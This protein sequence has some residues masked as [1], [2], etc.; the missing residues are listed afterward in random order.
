MREL[1]I[2]FI[3]KFMRGAHVG[4]QP[5]VQIVNARISGTYPSGGDVRVR[6]QDGYHSYATV[7]IQG[8]AIKKFIEAGLCENMPV[9]KILKFG[10]NHVQS[11]KGKKLITITD[12]ELIRIEKEIISY[13]AAPCLPHSGNCEDYLAFEKQLAKTDAENQPIVT[14]NTN[15]PGVTKKTAV[16]TEITS[17]KPHGIICPINAINP[18]KGKFL[19][20][21]VCTGKDSLKTINAA[22]GPTV[23]LNFTLADKDGNDVRIVAFGDRA[24]ELDGIIQEELTISVDT[25][26]KALKTANKQYNVTKN[27]YEIVLKPD[28]Q[29][30]VV[31]DPHLK[32]PVPKL[33]LQRVLLS[34]IQYKSGGFVDILGIITKIGNT[35]EINTKNGKTKKRE[36]QLVDE[37]KVVVKMTLWG[38]K[39]NEYDTELSEGDSIIFKNVTVREFKSSYSLSYGVGTKRINT[40]DNR[41]AQLLLNW[42][43]SHGHEPDIIQAPTFGGNNFNL[44]KCVLIENVS[45][46]SVG[47]LEGVYFNVVCRVSI[48]GSTPCYKAC[49]NEGCMKKVEE[50]N[51]Q[52]R[53]PKCNSTKTTFKWL[54]ILKC[55]VYDCSGKQWVTFFGDKAEKLTGLSADAM[56]NM[57]RMEDNS[58]SR[59]LEPVKNSTFNLRIRAKQEMY[60]GT[61]STKWNC[62]AVEEVKM[63][64]YIS[65]LENMCEKMEGI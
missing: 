33:N 22:K 19:I 28:C 52:F 12:F 56:G 6:L 50:D 2:G 58:L 46:N 57:Q 51:D 45:E 43:E 23:V 35:D 24:T 61:Y 49:S 30:A 11:S 64:E 20:M 26:H 39:C 32:V 31:E 37:S 41:D 63:A 7:V 4:M 40:T 65:K 3:Q 16:K 5:I 21:G 34:D 10:V 8:H 47:T 27:E 53:C 29:V 54:A 48:F 9:I 1:S 18:Y 13:T 17:N 62:M 15:I 42:Y 14:Q 25:T 59:S 44:D 60:N 38:D 55:E 36:I